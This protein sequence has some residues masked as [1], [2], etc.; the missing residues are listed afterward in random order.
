MANL[1]SVKARAFLVVLVLLLVAPVQ[2]ARTVPDIDGLLRWQDEVVLQQ[3]LGSYPQDYRYADVLDRITRRLNPHL[4]AVY[5][6]GAGKE[7]VRYFVFLSR[8][9]FNAQTWN[10][11]IIFDSLLLDSLRNLS[12]AIAVRGSTNDPFVQNLA[13][14]VTRAQAACKAGSMQPDFGNV[15]N[16]YNLPIMYGLPPDQ[17][18]RADALFEEM[19]AAWMAHEASHAF[20][21]HVRERVEARQLAHIYESRSSEAMRRHIQQYLSYEYGRQKELE[22]DAGAVRLIRRAGYGIDGFVRTF[23]FAQMI[24]ELTGESRVPVRTHPTPLERI[25]FVQRVADEAPR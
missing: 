4:D 5:G 24:E 18:D 15:Q 23:E 19:L 2:A 17:R 20:L 16:P 14:A 22:A 1:L 7:Q 11:V 8:I 9:G 13:V 25:R 10:R 12:R 3:L 6:K 21:N